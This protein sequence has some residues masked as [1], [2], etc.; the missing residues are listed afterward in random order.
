MTDTSLIADDRPATENAPENADAILEMRNLSRVFTR[1]PVL[2]ETLLKLAG[3]TP[4]IPVLRA[5]RSVNLSVQRGEVLGLAGE[6]G[7]GKSTLGRMMTGILPASEGTVSYEG[8]D[9]ATLRGTALKDFTL[10]VQMVFQDPYSSLNPRQRVAAILAEPL[11][12]HR[13]DLSRAQI[14][15]RVDAALEEVGLDVSYRDR[16]PHQFSG[17][18]RQRIGIARALIVE[19]QFLVCD[20]PIAALDVSI[21]AQVINLFLE[22]RRKRNLTY[23]F[24][25]HDLSVVRHMADRVAIMYLGEIVELAPTAELFAAP[26]HPYTRTLLEQIPSVRNRKRSFSAVKGELPSPLNPPSGCPFHPRCPAAM[27]Q[28]SLDAPQL[29]QIA[30]GRTVSCH[31]YD[32]DTTST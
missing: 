26:K 21:Q 25:S 9:A 27:P 5:V 12:V 23:L 2:A 17:G 18:Q 8:A 14:N 16:F 32:K 15:A 4:D 30:P 13:P 20:E 10:G 31:L 29:Q 3:R 24:I 6:S 7:C 11:K 28:C 1:Q 19:P 22:L